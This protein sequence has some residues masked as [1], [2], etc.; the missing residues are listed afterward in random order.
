MDVK[1]AVRLAKT[2]VRE[3][4]ADENIN[5]VGLEETRFDESSGQWTI[6]IGFRR[7]FDRKTQPKD[8]FSMGGLLRQDKTYENRWYKTVLIDVK[9]GQ[10]VSMHDFVL[11]SAA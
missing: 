2:Y 3:V 8:N 10:I 9:T 4:F 5:E 1:D 7:P 11:R 6:T